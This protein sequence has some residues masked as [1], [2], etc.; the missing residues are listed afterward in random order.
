MKDCQV[1]EDDIRDRVK[2]RSKTRKADPT[3][4][5]DTKLGREREI[6]HI[7]NMILSN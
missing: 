3:S 4:M 1:T 5:W 2:W 7:K 6:K